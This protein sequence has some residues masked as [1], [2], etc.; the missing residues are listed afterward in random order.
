MAVLF[1]KCAG[2]V[3]FHG[4]QVFLLQNDKAEWVLP[5]GIVRGDTG[6]R[7]TALSRVLNEAG[8]SAKILEAVGETTYEFYSVSRRM[9]VCNQILWYIMRA[10]DG[11]YAVNRELGFRD[12]GY[13]PMEEALDLITY[14]QDRS[15]LR[16]AY[17]RYRVCLAAQGSQSADPPAPAGDI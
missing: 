10:D 11:A 12:G 9:P 15:L 5:K 7:E 14:T 16:L 13:F 3:V 2:G 8:V 6:R 1:R 4:E 17:E